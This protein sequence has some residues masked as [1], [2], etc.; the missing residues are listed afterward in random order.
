MNYVLKTPRRVPGD[1]APE[2]GSGPLTL[3]Q[4][5]RL[6]LL[7]KQAW[8]KRGQPGDFDTWRRTVAERACGLR[9]SR[10]LQRDWARLKAAFLDEM[11]ESGAALDTLLRDQD[12]ARRIALHKLWQACT[13]RGLPMAYPDVICRRQYHCP[14]G[15][16][17]APQL[18]RLVFTVK[19]RRKK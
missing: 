12:N 14:L 11:G 16:A 6:V 8:L 2:A 15:E 3:R 5:R 13:A 1:Y 7:A 4:K 9:I 19:N 10:A 17:T 18:W